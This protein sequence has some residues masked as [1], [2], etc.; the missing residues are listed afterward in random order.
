L[1]KVTEVANLGGLLKVAY[2]KVKRAK[3]GGESDDAAAQ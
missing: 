3:S 2:D 1:E